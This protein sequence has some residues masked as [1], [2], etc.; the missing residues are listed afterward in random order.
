MDRRALLG[1]ICT[2]SIIALTGCLGSD[3]GTPTGNRTASATPTP[4]PTPALTDSEFEVTSTQ[5]GTETDSATVAVNG[6]DVVVEGTTWGRNGCRTAELD[7]VNYDGD[8]LTVAVAT[9]R[10]DDAGD[11][12]TQGIVELSYRATVEFENGLPGTVVVTH[13]HGDGPETVVTTSP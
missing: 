2:G 6:H 3:V 5:G 1:T 7:S 4:A 11:A 9:T 12:C 13:D 10:R 8:T